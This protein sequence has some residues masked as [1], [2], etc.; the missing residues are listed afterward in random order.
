MFVVQVLTIG[1]GFSRHERGLRTCFTETCYREKLSA[2]R[3]P[4]VPG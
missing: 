3:S 4:T 1:P 2:P